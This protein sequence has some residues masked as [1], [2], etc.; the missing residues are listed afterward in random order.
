MVK[1]LAIEIK[2]GDCPLYSTKHDI[3]EY[4]ELK[5]LPVNEKKLIGDG[6]NSKTFIKR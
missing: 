4:D 6:H 3:E 2:I 5:K 1:S